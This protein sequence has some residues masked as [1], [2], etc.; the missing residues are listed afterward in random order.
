M[1]AVSKV[2]YALTLVVLPAFTI[3]LAHSVDINA[4]PIW[5][6]DDA[7]AKCPGV[8]QAANMTWSGNWTTPPGQVNSVC[9]CTPK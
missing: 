6:N 8:C 1:N 5:D 2:F 4:G 7:Q 3:S 9:G